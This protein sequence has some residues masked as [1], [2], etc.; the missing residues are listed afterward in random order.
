MSDLSSQIEGFAEGLSLK[1]KA[2]LTRLLISLDKNET[3]KATAAKKQLLS[4]FTLAAKSQGKKRDL[5]TSALNKYLA[6]HDP[7]DFD[8]QIAKA[9]SGYKKQR[10][11]ASSELEQIA[12]QKDLTDAERTVIQRATASDFGDF[13]VGVFDVDGK[14][15]AMPA[16]K[17]GTYRIFANMADDSSLYDDID[18]VVRRNSTLEQGEAFVRNAAAESPKLKEAYLKYLTKDDTGQQLVGRIRQINPRLFNKNEEQVLDTLATQMANS[19]RLAALQTYY[20]SDLSE[21]TAN[22]DDL[23][24]GD[25][26]R[27]GSAAGGWTAKLLDDADE[28]ALQYVNLAMS[29]FPDPEMPGL[30]GEDAEGLGLG[31]ASSLAGSDTELLA[32]LIGASPE[33]ARSLLGKQD[34]VTKAVLAFEDARTDAVNNPNFL[35]WRQ[36]TGSPGEGVPSFNEFRRYNQQAMRAQRGGVFGPTTKRTGDIRL[37]RYRDRTGA[38]ETDAGTIYF[39]DENGAPVRPEVV[40]EKA[41]SAV[42]NASVV[43]FDLRGEGADG[44]SVDKDGNPIIDKQKK[45]TVGMAIAATASDEMRNAL[46]SEGAQV[47]F[48]KTT[49][50]TVILDKN[51]VVLATQRL[52]GEDLNRLTTLG[53]NSEVADVLGDLS[54]FSKMESDNAVKSGG[55]AGVIEGAQ[56]NQFSPYVPAGFAYTSEAPMT[57][58]SGELVYVPG[59]GMVANVMT[60]GKRGRGDEG[61]ITI[62]AEDIVSTSNRGREGYEKAKQEFAQSLAANENLTK[63]QRAEILESQTFGEDEYRKVFRRPLR[64]AFNDVFKGRERR[65]KVEAKK[66]TMPFQK[67][68]SKVEKTEEEVSDEPTTDAPAETTT[69]PATVGTGGGGRRGAGGTGAGGTGAG[70]GTG[71]GVG[72]DAGAGAE[73]SALDET[74]GMPADP[75]LEGIQPGASEDFMAEQV[76]QESD[77]AELLLRDAGEFRADTETD[78]GEAPNEMPEEAPP[79]IFDPGD[80]PG[81]DYRGTLP[82]AL[83]AT[84]VTTGKE[85][86]QDDDKKTPEPKPKEDP[87]ALRYSRAL[88]GSLR[89]ASLL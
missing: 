76:L 70:T 75:Y 35:L 17:Y 87:N 13:V 34:P 61:M 10:D 12:K 50:D 74:T 85:V 16:K 82:K 40:G 67:A 49:G 31:T 11:K 4:L 83:Q 37:I 6:A 36:Q 47:Y 65:A 60:R 15:V 84:D 21:A 88:K 41:D 66:G 39:Y 33:A 7:G 64:V 46:R 26:D 29:R 72:A 38:A 57:T 62:P 81:P 25:P 22:L 63:D 86:T 20:E 14:T 18:Q 44:R 30:T 48:D 55:L 27:I 2:T 5:Y 89:G 1:D 59:Q 53:S 58:L 19:T 56:A 73:D 79:E 71:T 69:P 3:A 23:G 52:E 78:L 24:S 51:R 42:R 54:G 77:P 68:L 9:Q 80:K 8:E 28:F 32:K 43:M 45:N